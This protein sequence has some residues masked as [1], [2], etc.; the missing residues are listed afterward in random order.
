MPTE[1]KTLILRRKHNNKTATEIYLNSD[2]RPKTTY[3]SST[4]ITFSTHRKSLD[5]HNIIP[6]TQKKKKKT[7]NSQSD[8]TNKSPRLEAQHTHRSN[9]LPSDRTMNLRADSHFAVAHTHA[10]SAY[11]QTAI[12]SKNTHIPKDRRKESARTA[13]DILARTRLCEM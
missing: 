6:S 11:S 7:Q 10:V 5:N 4:D 9:A 12:F 1:K 8:R 13:A 2:I 3:F